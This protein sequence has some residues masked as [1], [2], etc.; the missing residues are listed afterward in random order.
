MVLVPEEQHLV[1]RIPKLEIKNFDWKKMLF[2]FF[3]IF[4]SFIS[5]KLH[6]TNGAS[7]IETAFAAKHIQFWT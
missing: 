7:T 4:F 6:S 3:L 5:V 1:Q 2:Y